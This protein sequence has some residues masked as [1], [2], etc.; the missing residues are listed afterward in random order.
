[1]AM[2]RENSR[3]RT[4][5]KPSSPL[6]SFWYQKG[7]RY[8]AMLLSFCL[9][10]GNTAGTA[11][12][13]GTGEEDPTFLVTRADLYEALQKAA[14]EGTQPEENLLFQGDEELQKAYQDLLD[15]DLN[16]DLYEL[17][18]EIKQDTKDMELRIF[19]C[20]DQGVDPEKRYVIAGD[21]KIIFL[22]TNKTGQEQ[23]ATIQVDKK[24]TEPISILPGTALIV[25]D[26]GP[27]AAPGGSGAG[28]GSG[29]AANQGGGSGSGGGA[30]EKTESQEAA[31]EKTSEEA[32][33]QDDG[34]GGDSIKPEDSLGDQVEPE[35]KTENKGDNPSGQEEASRENET[36][37][38]E[39]PSK[40]ETKKEDQKE[41]ELEQESGTEAPKVPET[42]NGK[43][44]SDNNK[45]E[46][47]ADDAQNQGKDDSKDADSTDKGEPEKKDDNADKNDAGQGEPEKKDEALDKGE[48]E[49]NDGS[50][51]KSDTG[52][53]EPEKKDEASDK[54][55][56]EKKDDTS[57]KSEPEKNEGASD[58][59]E[60]E[61]KE[62]SN[63][64]EKGSSG[65]K[66]E[67]NSSDEKEVSLS[68]SVN[69]VQR[70]ASIWG[71]KASS[72]NGTSVKKKT[73]SGSDASPSNA[74]QLLEGE[75]YETILLEKTKLGAAAFVTTASALGLDD[76]SF[77]LFTI[78]ENSELKDITVRVAAEPGDLPD[79]VTLRVKELEPE[80]EDADQYKDAEEALKN[81]G[82]QYD[83][84]MALDISFIDPDGNEVEPRGDVQVSIKV[85]A[86]RLP[87]EVNP[88]S[89]SVQHLK[90]EADGSVQVNQV[91]DVT[92]DTDGIVEVNQDEAVA[93][94]SVESFS[95]FTIIWGNRYDEYFNVTVHYVD[96]QNRD[97]KGETGTITAEDE[98]IFL[99]DYSGRADTLL[100]YKEA[101]LGSLNGDVIDR[102]E[103]S[104]R[105]EGFLIWSTTIHTLT[106][107]NGGSV[108][109]TIDEGS[110]EELNV[111][112]VYE[113][114]EITDEPVTAERKL[115]R[116]KTV[117][118]NGDGT[119]D[120]NLSVSGA[121]STSTS[122]PI[123]MDILLIV[124]RSGS[125]G[126]KVGG[127]Y[128]N[129]ISRMD[130]AKEAVNALIGKIDEKKWSNG[131]EVIDVRYN[132]VT[133]DRTARSATNGWGNFS[134]SD[135]TGKMTVSSEGT[136][137]EA[138]IVEGK[139]QLNG[140]RADAE[141]I[142]IFLTDGEPTYALNESGGVVG[143]GSSSKG[144]YVTRAINQIKGM[145]CTSFYAVSCGDLG[146]SGKQNLDNLCKAVPI[147][148][149]GTKKVIASSDNDLI[150]AFEQI[151][152]Q[153]T[154]ILCDHVEVKDILSENVEVVMKSEVPEEL[155]VQIRNKDGQLVNVS[156]G[157]QNPGNPVNLPKTDQNKS[158]QIKAIYNAGAVELVFPEEYKLESGWT[159][160]ATIKIKPTEKAYENYR[161]NHSRYPDVADPETGTYAKQNGLYSNEIATVKYQFNN[162]TNTEEFDKPV[163][164]IEPGTLV[165]QK[166][167][168]G[169][170]Q[171]TP[172]ERAALEDKL[173]FAVTLNGKAVNP[174]PKLK[175]FK[176]I[177]DDNQNLYY[178]LSITGLSPDTRYTVEET[179]AN[180]D[181]YTLTTQING[182][183]SS[184]KKV[185]GTIPKGET[186][187]E[188]FTNTYQQMAKLTVTKK[189]EGNMGDR[190]Q[191]FRFKY[192]V[193]GV[194][195][196]TFDLAHN[197]SK[198]LENIPAN[199]TVKITELGMVDAATKELIANSINDYQTSASAA[200]NG[201]PL[202]VTPNLP[203]REFTLTTVP[204]DMEMTIINSKG[205]TPPTGLTSHKHPYLWML[206]MAAFGIMGFTITD[207]SEKAHKVR[208]EE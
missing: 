116:S 15:F 22:V 112:L 101:H 6:K 139:K 30:A 144:F 201:N 128:Y 51:N 65:S 115:S 198:V 83:G 50:A 19:A 14:A 70:V 99:E 149:G 41:P 208:D 60:S 172:E 193:N 7:R 85:N 67:E 33:S 187:T 136:N 88:E 185:S 86:E 180:V 28:A 24:R 17:K 3:R 195:M 94:F 2:E 80:G 98:V 206:A 137:Y 194:D 105:T 134:K 165:I 133:F 124:D 39:N 182:T 31:T 62:D 176:K 109:K 135:I 20:L 146:T 68:V 205:I 145:N 189:V 74:D 196:G 97:I 181:G 52:Q 184:D 131:K 8:C 174:A 202:E 92:D 204:T 64:E 121:V 45:E 183:E 142:V 78:Y 120:L 199:V 162:A 168:E 138:G 35:D 58:R 140:K 4:R 73:A 90:E 150:D 129:P 43:N 102:I 164:R 71:K 72:S 93:E 169:L 190:T 163:I 167:V 16:A 25:E 34:K 119:Y 117:E 200:S 192:E 61:R 175:D 89:L 179:G 106:F 191:T 207:L 153:T 159:Y 38:K 55:E 79:N 76:D 10:L 77:K 37:E 127:S 44:E 57:H 132:L 122:D 188:S 13:A 177:L 130:K 156:S 96:S 12:A 5:R 29:G 126:D 178:E 75:A 107:K 173:E 21:E 186:K 103:I 18:P 47:K 11:F 166:R 143:D 154:T 100:K 82:A 91:A 161:N 155:T 203:E 171:L 40:E 125:M 36:P 49:K 56:A 87:E 160:T 114:S 59:K 9:I 32:A 1:M 53:G 111:Y 104:E 108:V 170:E 42:D 84:M 110:S 148:S 66:K 123:K 158:A 46:I 63:T 118:D 48:S 23:E 151:A 69:Q 95:T 152:L 157:S 81:E 54:G 113:T 26:D 141:T 197:Q 27:E 147:A